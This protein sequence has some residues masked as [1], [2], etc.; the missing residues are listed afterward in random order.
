MSA[1]KRGNYV[2]SLVLGTDD[3]GLIDQVSE[4]YIEWL[5]QEIILKRVAEHIDKYAEKRNINVSDMAMNPDARHAVH[6][7]R[8]RLETLIAKNLYTGRH[9]NLVHGLAAVEPQ[10]REDYPTQP[11]FTAW[12]SSNG[13]DKSLCR[14]APFHEA[15]HPEEFIESRLKMIVQNY[16]RSCP[17]FDSVDFEG[18]RKAFSY[19]AAEL[20]K[21]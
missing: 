2:L 11:E 8:E 3:Q 1:T 5:K 12:L 15:E 14:Y 19:I 13:L 4:A 7:E 20:A 18:H 17:G 9:L 16:P 6:K 10:I 21:E